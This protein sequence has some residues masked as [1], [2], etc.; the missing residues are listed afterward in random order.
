[1]GSRP[2]NGIEC[3]YTIAAKRLKDEGQRHSLEEDQK[4]KLG[5]EQKFSFTFPKPIAIVR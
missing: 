5:H 1:M 2:K 3:Y 4:K